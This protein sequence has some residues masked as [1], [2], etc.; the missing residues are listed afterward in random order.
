MIGWLT[1][2]LAHIY[3]LIGFRNRFSVALDWTWSCLTFQRGARLI[4]GP[5]EEAVKCGRRD[6]EAAIFGQ[7][8]L[9]NAEFGPGRPCSLALNTSG[10]IEP[11]RPRRGARVVD[12]DG[13]ENRCTCKRTVSSNLTLSAR[14]S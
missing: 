12:W 6:G 7:K 3:F 10:A 1:W 11:D 13:L 14:K 2:S 4:T 8:P 5:M 9:L